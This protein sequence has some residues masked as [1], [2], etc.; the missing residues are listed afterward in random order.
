MAGR[1]RSL[2]LMGPE[3]TITA[4][5]IDGLGAGVHPVQL[6]VTDA[7]GATG[8]AVT[9]LTVYDNRPF[10]SFT[11]SPNPA[12]CSQVI[13]FDATA[14]HHGRPDRSI[15]D[16][17]WDFGDGGTASGQVVSH[18]YP[19]FGIYSAALTVTDDNLPP[20]SASTTVDILVDLGNRPPVADPGGPYVV[21]MGSPLVLDGTGSSDPDAGCGDLVAAYEWR[22]GGVIYLTGP[23]PSLTA[24]QIDDLGEGDHTVQLTVMDTFGE[25]GTA[26]TT[27]TIVPPP[28]AP[29][30][31]VDDAYTVAEDTP[32]VVAAPGVLT[33]DTRS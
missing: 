27:L 10:A 8:V 6:T 7:L 17:S 15:V 30:V 25:T 2:A 19:A 12:A 21:E 3:L 29:P 11:A 13:T 28:N 9:T 4:E 33:N 23:N 32:L 24:A 20:K 1:R 18:L 5:Q 14:S 22:V 26:E 31:A 16:Y